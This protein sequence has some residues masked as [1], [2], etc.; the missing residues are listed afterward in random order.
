[1][2]SRDPWQSIA[3]GLGRLTTMEVVIGANVGGAEPE[4]LFL[5]CITGGKAGSGGS[6]LYSG[7]PVLPLTP[8]QIAGPRKNFRFS[9][10]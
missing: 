5:T 3:P 1:M 10:Q 7:T 6:G 8:L 2:L 4:D 9:I